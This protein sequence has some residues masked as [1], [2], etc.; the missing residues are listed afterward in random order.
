MKG[1]RRAVALKAS[2][3]VAHKY[4]SV[5]GGTLAG[6]PQ[7]ADSDTAKFHVTDGYIA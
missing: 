3:H 6:F 2:E 4:Q 1:A 5:T 7:E